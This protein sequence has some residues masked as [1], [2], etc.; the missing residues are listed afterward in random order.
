[1]FTTTMLPSILCF[2]TKEAYVLTVINE[3]RCL[4]I[5]LHRQAVEGIQHPKCKAITTCQR[6]CLM[7]A[8]ISMAIGNV[9]HTAVTG[10]RGAVRLTSA[11]ACCAVAANRANRRSKWLDLH[12]IPR[13]WARVD[14]VQPGRANRRFS[15]ISLDEPRRETMRPV[16]RGRS[17]IRI[18]ALGVPLSSTPWLVPSGLV[19]N[20]R[21]DGLIRFGVLSFSGG[22]NEHKCRGSFP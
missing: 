17:G 5:G 7:V 10:R 21:A 9:A 2:R 16:H 6:M 3:R 1:M 15:L 13:G 8:N 11:S 19:H 18:W 4:C 12:L 22:V 14:V 20:K